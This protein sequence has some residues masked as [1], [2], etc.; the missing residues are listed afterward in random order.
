MAY[1]QV[2]LAGVTLT[3]LSITE[4]SMAKPGNFSFVLRGYVRKWRH[5]SE[6]ASRFNR[7]SDGIF[8]LTSAETIDIFPEV[9]PVSIN[10][11]V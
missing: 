8:L 3:S 9:P 10:Q 11:R 4:V 5:M 6:D 1:E 2:D 7:Q